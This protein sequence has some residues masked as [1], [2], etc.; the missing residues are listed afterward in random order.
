[1]EFENVKAALKDAIDIAS[2]TDLKVKTD[3]GEF[4]VATV[5]DVQ[6]LMN[7]RLYSIA[8]LLGMSDLYLDDK[9]GDSCGRVN[10]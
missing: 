9:A 8:D 6:E 2:G 1:M 3:D 5:K 4:R 10:S 7:E